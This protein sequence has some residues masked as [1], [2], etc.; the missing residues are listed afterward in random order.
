MLKINSSFRYEG[1]WNIKRN[2]SGPPI[3]TSVQRY[4]GLKPERRNESLVTPWFNHVSETGKVSSCCSKTRVVISSNLSSTF[5][6]LALIWPAF[7][8]RLREGTG[9]ISISPESKIN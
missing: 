2:T 3:I 8:V 1:W 9:M 5:K 7:S 6:L 4:I